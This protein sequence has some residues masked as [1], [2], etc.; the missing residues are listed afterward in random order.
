MTIKKQK[1]EFEPHLRG[2]N[3]EDIE[4]YI[5]EQIRPTTQE[6]IISNCEWKDRQWFRQHEELKIYIM[7]R[8]EALMQVL[9]ELQG[10]KIFLLH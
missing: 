7:N 4:N 1:K 2:D 3:E 8:E 9:V 6:S 10:H 5:D